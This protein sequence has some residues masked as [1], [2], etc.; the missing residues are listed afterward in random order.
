MVVHQFKLVKQGAGAG[1]VWMPLP[2]LGVEDVS[3]RVAAE[4]DPRDIDPRKQMGALGIPH[5]QSINE[6]PALR[7]AL[8]LEMC[9]PGVVAESAQAPGP[10]AAG[11]WDRRGEMRMIGIR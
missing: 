1:S 11:Q 4:E 8:E 10:V 9:Q 7:H 2:L 6:V 3:D 5:L